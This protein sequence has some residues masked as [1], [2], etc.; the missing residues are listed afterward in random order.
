MGYYDQ[1]D[2]NQNKRKKSNASYFLAGLGGAIIGALLI[3]LF[4]PGSGL[5]N[6]ETTR[7]KSTG[8]ESTKQ[9]QQNLTVD[10]TSAVTNAV[11]KASDAVVGISNIQKTNFWGQGGNA[12][13]SSAEAGTGSGVVYK[14]DGGKAYIVTNNHVIEGANELEVT[15][16]DGTK[17]P[18]KLQGS[19]P[20]TDL[21]VIVV[22]GDKI[23]TIAE[24]G[25]SSK[26]KPGEPVIAIGNPLGLQ[27]SGSVTQGIISGLERTIEV[28]IN[29]DGQV[30]WNAE[31]IQTDAAINPGN[32]GG[33]LV[34]MSGQVIGINSMKIAEN[35][36]EGI[37]LSIPIDSVIPIINDIEEFGEVKRAYLGVNLT[38]VKEISQYH[39][40]NTLKLPRKVTEGVAITGVQSNSPASRAGLKE[41]DVIVGMDNEKIHDVVELRKYLYIDKKIGDKVKIIY[42]RD[43]K[44]ETTEVK[45]SSSEI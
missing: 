30:D 40:K 31:V 34:N 12:E 13:D 11:G 2:E 21:A 41:F 35:A 38:S 9:S 16:S 43:G 44:K 26:L 32:S 18:A 36:V 3:L 45:L 17:L 39:Q 25:K 10:V 1:N 6:N 8:S 24:F 19:D 42:Y 27:F 7:E 29:E 28:D 33:A 20:W 23:K 5:L 4:F 15:L 37:G 22:N 14:K